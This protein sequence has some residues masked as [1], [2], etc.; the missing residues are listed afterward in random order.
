MNYLFVELKATLKKK[1]IKDG[2]LTDKGKPNDKTPKD[3]Y[4][5]YT[6]Y[7]ASGS[8]D[9]KSTPDVL[10]SPNGTKFKAEPQEVE[11][12]QEEEELPQEGEE[13]SE[14]KKK[15]KKKKKKEQSSD[16]E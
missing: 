16:S 6:D 5:K 10:S 15:K 4:L 9:Q 12:K 2:L 3:W 7:S 1:L 8:G 11:A 13:V 14:K